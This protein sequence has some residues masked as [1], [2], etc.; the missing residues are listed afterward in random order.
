M[1]DLKITQLPSASLVTGSD[2]LPIV[3][4]G[5]TDQITVNNFGQSIFN[6]GLPITASSVN[7]VDYIDFNTTASVIQPFLGRLSWNQTDKTLDLGTGDG[8]TT[9]QIGQ[10]TVYPPIV[11]KDSINLGEGTLVMIDPTDIAQGNRIRVVRAITN[12]TYP[13]QYLVGVLTED[14]ARNQEGFATW[15]GYVRNLSITTLIANGIKPA[16][17][18]WVEGTVLYSNPS[19]PGGFTLTQPEAPAVDA[20][21]AVITEINGNNLTMLVRPTLT[22]TLGELN[23][24]KDTTTTSSYGD[25]LIKSGSVWGTGKQLSGSYG[26]TGS[27]N[28]TSFTGSLLGTASYAINHAV[29]TSSYVCDGILNANQTF[30]TGSDATIAF[31][32]YI[33]PNNWIA[34]NQFKPTIAGYYNVSFG[35]WLQNPGIAT[36]QVNTQMRKNGN[37]MIISQQ[38]LNNGTG[39]GL[40]GSRIIQM[41]GTTDYLDWT[42]F[43]GTAGSGT[44]GT[45]LQGS[46][47]GQGT[48]F[49]AFL[50]T[51]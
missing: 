36:N 44:T 16:G 46:A 24:I 5:V 10:E 45:I 3:R 38:P 27:L 15:F 35:V 49:S 30:A 14:I 20:T 23:N 12:G 6:L 13:S 34:S 19:I 48:W 50:I 1:A 26:L 2:V 11:N 37:S 31:V 29:I 28:A 9:L 7:Q 18:N 43:Q 8:N 21:M 4:G 17:E 51:Q 22:V 33:D 39:I 32:D 42:I 41:N 25:L 47:N 40:G